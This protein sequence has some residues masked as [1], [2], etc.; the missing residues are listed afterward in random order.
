M[1]GRVVEMMTIRLG[2]RMMSDALTG[3]R[4]FH[5]LEVYLHSFISFCRLINF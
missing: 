1:V 3:S 2:M 4:I 5:K